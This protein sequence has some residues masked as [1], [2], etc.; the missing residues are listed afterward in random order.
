MSLERDRK[1][2]HL[3]FSLADMTL[4]HP[5][6]GDSRCRGAANQEPANGFLSQDRMQFAKLPRCKFSSTT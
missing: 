6:A 3:N 5:V 4:C 1:Y 2:G